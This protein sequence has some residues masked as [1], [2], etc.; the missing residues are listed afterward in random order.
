MQ[1]TL[2]N[3]KTRFNAFIPL[4]IAYLAAYLRTRGHVIRA[5]D[6]SLYSDEA[7]IFE[8]IDAE[9]S[10][11]YGLSAMTPYFP[12]AG[13]IA[14][15]IRQTRP[16]ARIAWGGPHATIRPGDVLDNGLADYVVTGEGEQAFAELLE[17]M[18]CGGE[19]GTAQSCD[20]QVDR[21]VQGTHDIDLDSLPFPARNLFPV[22]RYISHPHPKKLHLITSRGCPFNCTY[23]QPTLDRIFGKRFRQRSPS[24]VLEEIQMLTRDYGVREYSFQ[25]DTLTVNRPFFIE[26]CELLIRSNADI[27]WKF[28]VRADTVDEGMLRL[29][30]RAGAREIAVGVESG[31]EQVRNKTYRKGVSR[32]DIVNCFRW[33]RRHGISTS[34]Y[35]MVGAPGETIDD[36]SRTVTL[37][38]EIKPDLFQL[39]KTTPLP[40]TQLYDLFMEKKLIADYDFEKT[41]YAKVRHSWAT[42]VFSQEEKTLVADLVQADLGSGFVRSAIRLARRP[43]RVRLRELAFLTL[44]TIIPFAAA[45]RVA[46]GRN[47]R[48][49]KSVA[50]RSAG[51]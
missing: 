6:T 50:D 26:F 10:D 47:N 22:D 33:A 5:I 29:S 3:V 48:S 27:R 40:G 31:D 11:A 43:D 9:H 8:A 30:A 17:R 25:D 19:A 51:A 39:S 32:Q 36:I 13:R 16:L 7:D 35:I 15:H 49:R 46:Y 4:G 18:G 2:I 45:Y 44:R 34:A 24:N 38:K 20:L 23:C 37:V 14:A 12:L 41:V 1:V 28:N 21:V 42:D